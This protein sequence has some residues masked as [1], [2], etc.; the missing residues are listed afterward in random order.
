[1]SGFC[2]L[3]PQV[4][5]LRVQGAGTEGRNRIAVKQL[6]HVLIIDRFDLLNLVGGTEAVK[7]MHEGNAAP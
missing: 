3:P 4:R 2:A 5:M 6:V 7:E 1:M